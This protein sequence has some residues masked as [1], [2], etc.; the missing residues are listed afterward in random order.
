VSLLQSFQQVNTNKLYKHA[1][2][3][4]IANVFDY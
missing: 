3:N 1:T 2:L 4:T